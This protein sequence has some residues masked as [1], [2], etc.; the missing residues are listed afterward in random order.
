MHK[1]KE[2]TVEQLIGK[3]RIEEDNRRSERRFP[4][5]A[6]PIKIEIH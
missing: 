1:I 4:N 2:M 6:K 3:L 5:T